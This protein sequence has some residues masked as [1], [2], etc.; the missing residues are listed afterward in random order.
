MSAVTA[1][2]TLADV[3]AHLNMP[4]GSHD[5]ELQGFI[6]AAVPVVE[7]VVQA[8]V[9]ATYTAEEHDARGSRVI[10][11]RHPP[12]Y[13]VTSVVEYRMGTPTTLTAVATPALGT[14][15]TYAVY[16]PTGRIMRGDWLGVGY[17]WTSY[18]NLLQVT[19][20]AGLGAVPPNVRLGALEIVRH[21]YQMTQQGG[22]PSFSG[23][24]AEDMAW[25]PSGFAIP[26]RALE[27]LNPNQRPPCVA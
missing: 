26:T 20:V 11:L 1:I 19:Y 18:G 15:N 3:Y 17:G 25:T 22:R 12:V 8:V 21:N 16:L 5:A 14:A 6:D 2:V 24:A 7:D 13:S 9:G 10:F 27:W 4:A 23:A